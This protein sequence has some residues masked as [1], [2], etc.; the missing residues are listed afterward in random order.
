MCCSGEIW[1]HPGI[2]PKTAQ[3]T[4]GYRNTKLIR[5]QVLLTKLF[6][7]IFPFKAANS[8]SARDINYNIPR[9]RPVQ[10]RPIKK[11]SLQRK[12]RRGKARVRRGSFINSADYVQRRLKNFCSSE[13]TPQLT[14]VLIAFRNYCWGCHKNSMALWLPDLFRVAKGAPDFIKS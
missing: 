3:Y 2:P 4:N 1:S 10:M 6:T 14:F 12:V 8:R 9:A 7:P 5:T 11:S 13:A